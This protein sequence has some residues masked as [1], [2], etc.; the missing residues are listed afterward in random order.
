MF[1]PLA[2]SAE[3]LELLLGVLAAPD[4]ERAIAWRVDL[5]EPRRTVVGDY[6]ED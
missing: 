3:D 6:R 2:R 1:G 5:P 4:A